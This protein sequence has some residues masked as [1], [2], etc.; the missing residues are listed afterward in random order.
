MIKI[1][2]RSQ[3]LAVL[4]AVNQKETCFLGQDCRCLLDPKGSQCIGEINNNK[5]SNNKNNNK[6]NNNK[7]NN[8]NNNNNK[9]SVEKEAKKKHLNKR[10]NSVL[11]LCLQVDT[12]QM[13]KQTAEK[14]KELTWL[15]SQPVTSRE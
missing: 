2:G 6:N 9:S 11:K 1:E 7:N 13:A 4:S 12:M 15:Y 10:A 14:K 5:N 3:C 8:N